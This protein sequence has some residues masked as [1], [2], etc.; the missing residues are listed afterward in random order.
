M[1]SWRHFLVICFLRLL[2][3]CTSVAVSLSHLVSFLVLSLLLCI[4]E[5]IAPFTSPLFLPLFLLAHHTHLWQHGVFCPRVIHSK[6]GRA[7]PFWTIFSRFSPPPPLYVPLRPSLVMFTRL[8]AFKT[9]SCKK[10]IT[11]CP[12]KVPR[13]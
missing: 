12:G 2:H 8:H 1:I 4:F 11:S 9:I 6:T 10:H 13:P 5:S 3:L 7:R